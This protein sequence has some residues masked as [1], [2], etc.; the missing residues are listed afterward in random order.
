[1]VI[2]PYYERF[3]SSEKARY[4]KVKVKGHLGKI[5]RSTKFYNCRW[6]LDIHGQ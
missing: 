6:I 2:W 1:M 3:D 5:K 4:D